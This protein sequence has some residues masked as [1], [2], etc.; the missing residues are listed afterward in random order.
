MGRTLGFAYAVVSNG[1]WVVTY[2]PS[3]IG[4]Q[5]DR[6]SLSCLAVRDAGSADEKPV[7]AAPYS[8]VAAEHARPRL[9]G[10]LKSLLQ[11]CREGSKQSRRRTSC[12]ITNC[13]RASAALLIPRLNRSA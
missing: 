8:L 3:E 13:W 9:D 10:H 1:K 4:K 6:F 11:S 5:A 7:S 2:R 12:V